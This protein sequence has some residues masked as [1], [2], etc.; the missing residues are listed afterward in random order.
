M[1]AATK[2]A[3]RPMPATADLGGCAL[4]AEVGMNLLK[5]I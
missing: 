3:E 4:S 1:P 2:V 5:S